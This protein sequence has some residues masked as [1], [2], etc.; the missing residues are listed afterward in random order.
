VAFAAYR[1]RAF[2]VGSMSWSGDF[3]DP[4]TFLGLL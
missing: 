3:D 1:N 4:V 2:Q